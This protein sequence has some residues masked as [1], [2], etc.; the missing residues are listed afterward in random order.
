MKKIVHLGPVK[1][2]K[3]YQ[4]ARRRKTVQKHEKIYIYIYNKAGNNTART[5]YGKESCRDKGRKV[6]NGQNC[7]GRVRP[8]L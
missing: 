4:G 5:G 2:A 7:E 6:R 3:V 1:L 8:L